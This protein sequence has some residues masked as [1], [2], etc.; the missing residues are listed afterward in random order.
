MLPQVVVRPIGEDDPGFR[1]LGSGVFSFA[2]L[3]ACCR[4]ADLARPI[5]AASLSR[6][7]DPE[8]AMSG[9]Q[10]A[11]SSYICRSTYNIT[12]W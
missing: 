11:T 4:R 2:V 8:I 3:P 6:V 10:V 1:L 7:A 9:Y 5:I 12:I